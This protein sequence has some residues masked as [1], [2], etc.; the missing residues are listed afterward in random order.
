MVSYS[1]KR[2]EWE[3]EIQIRYALNIYKSV[4]AGC[5]IVEVD[6]EAMGNPFAR[7]WDFSGLDKIIKIDKKQ[8][9]LSQ[10]FRKPRKDWHTGADLLVDFRIIEHR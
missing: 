8:I 3:M 5:E 1:P 10:R 2:H 6:K 4:W 7:E 9:H